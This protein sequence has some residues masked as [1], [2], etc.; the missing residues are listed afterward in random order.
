MFVVAVVFFEEIFFFDLFVSKFM[1]FQLI[2]IL[3]EKKIFIII[4]VSKE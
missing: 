2:L 4:W 1:F 3:G